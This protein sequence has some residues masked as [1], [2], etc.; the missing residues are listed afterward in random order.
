MS[1]H[2]TFIYFRGETLE[3]AAAKYGWTLIDDSNRKAMFMDMVRRM[4]MSYSYKPVL[5]LAVLACA[6]AKGR[7]KLSD[8]VQFFRSFYVDRHIRGLIVEKPN[9]LYCREDVTDKEID[10]N[11]LANPFKR[12]E[13]VQMM[14]YTKTLGIVEV[15]NSVWMRLTEEEKSEIRGICEEKLEGYYRRQDGLR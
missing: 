11:I 4:D 1:E 3:A 13:D 7:M 8:L 9:S 5:M 12:F 2:R 15:D 14:R 10:R 6:D